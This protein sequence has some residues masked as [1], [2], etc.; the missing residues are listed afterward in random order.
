MHSLENCSLHRHTSKIYLYKNCE[1]LKE[2]INIFDGHI[3][4]RTQH[5]INSLTQLIDLQCVSCLMP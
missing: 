1:M 3:H 4:T 2:K 5:G